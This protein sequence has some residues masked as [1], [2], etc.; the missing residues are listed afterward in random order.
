MGWLRGR[1]RRKAREK[2]ARAASGELPGPEKI[3]DRPHRMTVLLGALSPTLAL[4]ALAVSLA[5]L[6]FNRE[7]LEVAQK[8]YVSLANVKWDC[9]WG[10]DV[11][12]LVRQVRTPA[13]P[14]VTRFSNLPAYRMRIF[15]SL[16]NSGN[17]PAA[18]KDIELVASLDRGNFAKPQDAGNVTVR[19]TKDADT[20]Y[21]DMGSVGVVPGKSPRDVALDFGGPLRY[22]QYALDDDVYLEG[23]VSYTTVFGEC[24]S[25]NWRWHAKATTTIHMTSPKSRRIETFNVLKATNADLK[26]SRDCSRVAGS[27]LR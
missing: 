14:Y 4:A 1:E 9:K 10:P 3:A 7:S 18:I 23:R 11:N 22:G 13:Q 21:L 26:M 2:K 27:F 6:W 15:I 16:A 12:A 5:T 25:L 24:E 20:Y 17:T 8:A 19:D